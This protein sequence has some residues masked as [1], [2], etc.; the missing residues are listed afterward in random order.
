[1]ERKG[2]E[3]EIV[4]KEEKRSNVLKREVEKERKKSIV[5]KKKGRRT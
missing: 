2:E 1:M 5:Q 4:E 3:R